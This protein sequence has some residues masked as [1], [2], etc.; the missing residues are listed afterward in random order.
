MI[1][2]TYTIFITFQMKPN[3]LC[4]W[5]QPGEVSRYKDG[6]GTG[7]LGIDSLQEEEIFLYSLAARPTLALNKPP[8]QNAPGAPPG[9]KLPGREANHWSPSS[10]EI[11][12][13]GAIPSLLH[14]SSLRSA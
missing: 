4:H 14:I 3:L 2:I 10:V 12:S 6:L 1:L 13:E 5:W 11:K 9:I 8:M 7:R